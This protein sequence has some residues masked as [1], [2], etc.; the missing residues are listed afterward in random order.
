MP[1]FLDAEQ[2]YANF[3]RELPE[4]AYAAGEYP[5]W[6]HTSSLYAKSVVLKSVYQ[7]QALIYKNMFPQDSEEQIED[8][9]V[10][11]FGKK[12]P[13]NTTITDQQNAIIAQIRSQPNI[14]KWNLLTK[15][16]SLLPPGTFAQVYFSCNQTPPI[17]SLTGVDLSDWCTFIQNLHW[18]LGVDRLGV[19]TYLGIYPYLDVVNR[20]IAAYMYKIRIFAAIDADTLLA[21]D[22]AATQA[23][24]ARSTHTI[25][26]NQNPADFGLV[27]TVNN[28]NQFSLV[29]C[30]CVDESQTTGYRGLTQ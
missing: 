13:A 4:G 26:T 8:W 9:A 23:E 20:Q 25:D 21:I 18:R 11:A 2:V 6:L 24:P 28:V 7:N 3:Q 5:R 30:I 14:T 19:N 22:T 16:V 1:V 17:D 15:I 29:D 27:T 12:F 10:K